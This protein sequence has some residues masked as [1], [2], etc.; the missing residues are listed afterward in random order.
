M[1]HPVA[2]PRVY[3]VSAKQKEPLHRFICDGLQASGAVVIY[4][5]PLDEAPL[6]LTF[7]LPSGE[8]AGIV[9]YAF[10][11]NSKLTRN[12]PGDEHRFQV[13][14]GAKDGKLH[15]LWQDPFNLYTTLFCGIDPERGIF[16]GADPVLHNPTRFFISLEYKEKHV[17]DILRTGWS[18]WERERRNGD[19]PIE[20]L[21]GGRRENFLKYV[22]FE[23]AAAGESQGHRHLLA[24][25][26]PA[27][28]EVHGFGL[29]QTPEIPADRL[30]ALAH[31]FAM[32]GDEVLD[33]VASARRLKMAV[34]GW[35]A[36][37][38]LARQLREVP[39]VT[40]CHRKDEEG[41]P[42][43]SLRF[44]RTPLSVECKNVLRVVQSDGLARVDFQRTRTSKSDPC[45]RFYTAS[46][47]DLLAA[48]LNAIDRS[49][50]Y[51]FRS[52]REMAPHDVCPGKLS[53]RVKVDPSWFAD[54][55]AAL[56][57]AARLKT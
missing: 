31:E 49:W 4:A 22:Q 28:E 15:E 12:R 18:A 23:R 45:S 9:V 48:C 46:D 29:R 43:V 37:E 20:V 25:Q 8:R 24:E 54:A 57:H 3:G 32:S 1:K 53:H 40:D 56:Q 2:A 42:D 27:A 16:V 51:R 36:E 10:F 13:K 30:H 50:S 5:S 21:V 17:A 11:A 55:H 35:V 14:Y 41:G 19:D 34:R 6:R 39:G 44:E 26:H 38:H 47:F 52:T 33:L 7:E